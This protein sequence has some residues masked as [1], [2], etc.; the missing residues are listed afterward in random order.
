[1]TRNTRKSDSGSVDNRRHNLLKGPELLS[2][3]GLEIERKLELGD[4]RHEIFPVVSGSAEKKDGTVCAT[5]N[6]NYP[7]L[8]LVV[9]RES[10]ADVPRKYDQSTFGQSSSHVTVPEDSRSIL[11]ASDSP[12]VLKPYATFLR[13]PQVVPQRSANSSRSVD[14]MGRRN[15]LRSMPHYHQ[16]VKENATPNVEFTKW[17]QSTDNSHME[18]AEIRRENL[19]RLIRERGFSENLSAFA[20][21]FEP[22]IRSSYIADLIKAGSTKSFGEKAARKF[23]KAADLLPGQLDIPNSPLRI[24]PTKSRIEDELDWAIGQLEPHEKAEILDAAKKML[25]KRHRRKRSA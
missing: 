13:C 7:A 2:N 17:C 12:Q 23:E 10:L 14:D 4:R 3:S 18:I 1:M 8:R 24:D 21:R 5:K 15:S 20:R 9:S 19:N 16:S 6:T 22:P 25:D 11:I